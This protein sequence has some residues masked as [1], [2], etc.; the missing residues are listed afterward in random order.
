MA[1]FVERT[2]NGEYLDQQWDTDSDNDDPGDHAPHERLPRLLNRGQKKSLLQIMVTFFPLFFFPFP[3]AVLELIL[4]SLIKTQD[5]PLL[6][7]IPQVL[8]DMDARR[9][10]AGQPFFKVHK[11]AKL[12][13]GRF[14]RLKPQTYCDIQVRGE[15][16]Y[17]QVLLLFSS[18]DTEYIL[19]SVLTKETRASNPQ[20]KAAGLSAW[21]PAGKVIVVA[22]NAIISQVPMV[23][24]FSSPHQDSFLLNK[25]AL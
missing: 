15:S 13:E 22:L 9:R 3:V 12:G 20:V 14:L 4:L 24:D 21:R 8:F 7:S 17:C 5:L 11:S 10:T 16:T 25:Y 6:S 1:E 23:P 2:D 18:V 19:V